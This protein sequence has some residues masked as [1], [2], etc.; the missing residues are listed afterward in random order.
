MACEVGAVAD[1]IVDVVLDT[2]VSESLRTNAAYYFTRVRGAQG[3]LVET[4][5]GRVEQP[6][7]PRMQVVL[8]R[9]LYPSSISLGDVLE[10]LHPE[11][12]LASRLDIVEYGAQVAMFVGGLDKDEVSLAIDWAGG[13]E[14]DGTWDSRV[15][16]AAEAVRSRAA[17][18]AEAPAVLRGLASL[19]AK[20]ARSPR[21]PSLEP[22]DVQALGPRRVDLAVSAVQA[23]AEP[24]HVARSQA[25]LLR[26]GDLRPL[27]DLCRRT[28]QPLTAEQVAELAQGACNLDEPD[29]L[30]AII[31][32][33]ELLAGHPWFN[34]LFIEAGSDRDSILAYRAALRREREAEAAA[35]ELSRRGDPVE[36]PPAERIRIRIRQLE[37][38]EDDEQVG[39]FWIDLLRQM[40][41]ESHSTS[42]ELQVH[43]RFERLPGWRDAEEAT[44]HRLRSAAIRVLGRTDPEPASWLGS[45]KLTA[46]SIALDRAFEVL[47]LEPSRLAELPIETWCRQAAVVV[48]EPLGGAH[49]R[50]R[51][52]VR[53]QLM[54]AAPGAAAEAIRLYIDTRTEDGDLRQAAW[55]AEQFW[56]PEMAAELKDLLNVSALTAVAPL[57]EV[58]L[59]RSLDPGPQ[60][61]RAGI[62]GDVDIAAALLRARPG[63]ALDRLDMSDD[64]KARAIVRR[65]AAD[66]APT[67]DWPRDVRD[68]E[69]LGRLL[70]VMA[71]IFP[72]IHGRTPQ[73]ILSGDDFVM[74]AWSRIVQEFAQRGTQEAV[75]AFE[76]LSDF[77]WAA[78]PL[79]EA[80]D[81][82]RAAT[83]SPPKPRE[84]LAVLHHDRRRVA[85]DSQLLDALMSVLRE[86]EE[87][88]IRG[89]PGLLR[90][91]WCPVE[92]AWRPRDEEDLSDLLATQL[93]LRM[94]G[95]L[96]NREVQVVRR[97]GAAPGQKV[98]ILVQ[99]LLVGPSRT[100]HPPTVVVEVKPNW[101]R[102][103]EVTAEGQLARYL[104][105]HPRCRAGLVLVGWYDCTAWDADDRRRGAA[106]QRARRPVEA[107]LS[108]A[109]ASVGVALGKDVRVLGLDLRL[110]EDVPQ[111]A[112]N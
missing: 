48:G 62:D 23:G 27:L 96:A 36:P 10:A 42:M 9:A 85:S 44:R 57:V 1:T 60:V 86:I 21:R 99:A 40:T 16:P 97:R 39:Q 65:L 81:R 83:W 63:E 24:Y 105:G 100:Q 87:E 41:R 98:D 15:R 7:P 67:D 33:R 84:I 74:M 8:L 51:R 43:G 69:G 101:N 38:A 37:E 25:R 102:D 108:A 6:P 28:E 59:S 52:A 55:M 13:F 112:Q 49:D 79:A 82:W 4:A 50:W 34:R 32:S 70:V 14:P 2:G 111:G 3:R 29:D 92:A 47:S 68:D 80:R 22:R 90:L 11:G 46:L 18:L 54:T 78:R 72:D 58:M 93:R 88:D 77:P 53:Q 19:I 30:D 103:L 91:L 31:E 75:A 76:R 94:P 104:V 106:R 61:W 35:F 64:D 109:C 73:G 17:S 110:G 95:M 12:G 89:K 45:K 5:L 56:S 26:S 66:R 20:D 71:R 107:E